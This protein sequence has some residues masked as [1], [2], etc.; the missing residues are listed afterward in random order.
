[1]PRTGTQE[2][3][4]DALARAYA[5]L[6]HQPVVLAPWPKKGVTPIGPLPYPV[7]RHPRFFSTH[8]LTA[9]YRW[10][11]Q[12]HYERYPF[13]LLHCHGVYPPGYLA[14][15]SRTIIPTP[16]VL[17]SHGHI[18]RRRAY[19]EKPLIVERMIEGLQSADAL[20]AM[21]PS[22]RARLASFCPQRAPCIVDIPNGVH[23]ADYAERIPRPAE[24]AA[25]IEPGA[26]AIFIGRLKFRNGIDILLQAL[27]R[28]PTNDRVQ[29][30]LAGEGEERALLEILAEQLDVRTRIRFVGNA[31]GA[32]RQYLLQNARFGVVPARQFDG[33]DSVILEGYAAGLPM[34]A[35]DLPGWADLVQHERTGLL[36]PPEA[37]DELA[38]AM[39]RLF[40]D[41]ALV[42][43]MSVRASVF[44]KSY[45]WQIIAE[46]H[47]SLYRSLL[48]GG[49]SKAA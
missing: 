32:A 30:L 31:T 13:D 33:A 18:G 8:F 36:L 21:N 10:F 16:V 20:V 43:R 49:L 4:V 45:D 5:A 7:L 35:T 11:L 37:P 23:A 3:A 46:R 29:L 38:E 42:E 39:T 47:L 14:A 27:A 26:Y 6:G 22:I 34:I 19:L 24:L 28:T 41:D 15:L 1:L 48:A 2:I 40:A 44:A 17:T 12:N 25:D 9:W